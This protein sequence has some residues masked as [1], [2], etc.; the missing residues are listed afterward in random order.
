MLRTAV[1][2]ELRDWVD[3]RLISAHIRICRAM[4]LLLLLNAAMVAFAL[5]GHASPAELGL[6]TVSSLAAGA[7]RQWLAAGIARGR[8]QKRTGKMRLA[9]WLNSLWLG[10]NFGIAAALQLPNLAPGGQLLLAICIVGQIAAAAYMVR[11]L[12]RSAEVFVAALTLGLA[13]GLVRFGTP[14]ALGAVVV[15]VVASGLL[16][17]MVHTAHD[18]FVKRII[19]DRDLAAA[20]RTVKLLLNEY[21]ENGS[22]WLF[23][24]DREGRLVNVSSRFAAAAG[25]SSAELEGAQFC[26]LFVNDRNRSMLE[27]A[28]C[29]ARTV[30]DTVVELAAEYGRDARNWWSVSGRPCYQ[31]TSDKVAFRGVISDI[32]GQRQAENRVHH[33]AHYDALTG[34]PNRALFIERVSEL[35]DDGDG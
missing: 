2:P 25:C 3:N 7:H 14:V 20:G 33:M 24:A 15:L 29:E 17:R 1:A 32:T 21:E 8:R 13:I 30:R 31:S 11:T 28:F 12:P 18:L 23:E 35:L 34:L 6:F 5:V 4:V 27:Q 22:D 10:C 19:A 16:I 9:F 26:S